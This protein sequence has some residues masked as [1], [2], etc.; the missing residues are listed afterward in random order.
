[1]RWT[2]WRR[3]LRTHWRTMGWSVGWSM[4]WSLRHNWSWSRSTHLHGWRTSRWWK[5]CRINMRCRSL[6]RTLWW[7][8]T[9]WALH[10]RRT[11]RRYL[12]WRRTLWWK[13]L[14][15]WR[16]TP[17]GTHTRGTRWWT[18]LTHP[19]WLTLRGN[20][21]H[22][23]RRTLGARWRAAR[24]HRPHVRSRTVRSWRSIPLRLTLEP[25]RLLLHIRWAII[26][27]RSLH[28]WST[29][30]RITLHT[31]R[32]HWWSSHR[33]LVHRHPSSKILH[34]ALIGCTRMWWS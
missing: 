16:A 9:W 32:A 30:S 20:L 33:A 11:T 4:W 10:G 29:E 13:A 7:H 18:L 28:S 17:I 21:K 22:W 15:H 5:E 24:T 25:R 12:H 2:M 23:S 31:R 19:R 1:M 8:N 27:W 6:R 14:L 34:W 26:S 3:L